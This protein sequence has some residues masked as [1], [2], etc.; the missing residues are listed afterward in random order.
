MAALANRLDAKGMR[1]H[2]DAIDA[3]IKSLHNG[4]PRAFIE[5]LE[6]MAGMPDK[7]AGVM[8]IFR[9]NEQIVRNALDQLTERAQTQFTFYS[10][11]TRQIVNTLTKALQGIDLP[12]G[13]NALNEM[14]DQIGAIDSALRGKPRNPQEALTATINAVS[15]INDF[16]QN[17]QAY[18]RKQRGR[19]KKELDP[20]HERNEQIFE[21]MESERQPETQPVQDPAS[22]PVMFRKEEDAQIA[23][24]LSEGQTPEDISETMRMSGIEGKIEDSVAFESYNRFA[25]QLGEYVRKMRKFMEMKPEFLDKVKGQGGTEDTYTAWNIAQQNPPFTAEQVLSMMKKQNLV[26]EEAKIP[27]VPPAPAATPAAP[28]TTESTPERTVEAPVDTPATAEDIAPIIGSNQEMANK[29]EILGLAESA[30]I[31]KSTQEVTEYT[32]DDVIRELQS[33]MEAG[34]IDKELR[35]DVQN[36]ARMIYKDPSVTQKNKEEA[37]RPGLRPRREDLPS[38]PEPEAAAAPLAPP[39]TSKASRG[40]ILLIPARR[41]EKS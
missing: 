35:S 32:I 20:I 4:D 7:T 38:R 41:T 15:G 26:G 11:Q 9:S 29:L 28:A 8:D 5:V 12:R 17:P 23:Q 19:R 37:N 36:I 39:G 10:P 30:A 34:I 27:E 14:K 13:R 1:D 21:E 33:L 40:G 18:L 22:L 2:A 24:W 16:V 31:P 6:I 3:A 25:P